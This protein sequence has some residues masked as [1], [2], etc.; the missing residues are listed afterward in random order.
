MRTYEDVLRNMGL[1]EGIEKGLEK[2]RKEGRKEGQEEALE[3]V[4]KNLISLGLS[5]DVIKKATNLPQAV[6][7]K[8][9]QVLPSSPATKFS[10]T[11]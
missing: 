6:I 11:A 3:K 7:E 4:A 10:T 8:L 2:G 5:I 1:K 9:T